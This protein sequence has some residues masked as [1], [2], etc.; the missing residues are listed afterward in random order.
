MAAND[1][2]PILGEVDHTKP[3]TVELSYRGTDGIVRRVVRETYPLKSMV[4]H[5]AERGL[6]APWDEEVR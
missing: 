3:F 1:S 4:K 6:R 2:K 5:A